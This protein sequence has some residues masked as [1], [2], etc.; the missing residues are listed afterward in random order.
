M[1]REIFAAVIA[2]VMGYPAAGL[3]ETQS[4]RQACESDA[5]R[6]CWGAIPDPHRVFVCLAKNHSQLSEACRK[7]MAHYSPAHT[8]RGQW[9]DRQGEQSNSDGDWDE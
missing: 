4:E 5:F 7:V 8:H 3:A 9:T 2:C 6:V 1:K